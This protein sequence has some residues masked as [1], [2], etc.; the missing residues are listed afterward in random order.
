MSSLVQR[1]KKEGTDNEEFTVS[2]P[3][4][5]SSLNGSF[6]H[7]PYGNESETDDGDE[8]GPK[9]SMLTLLEEVYL[10]GLKDS[11]VRLFMF[12]YKRIQR[13]CI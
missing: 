4:T 7:S 9:G 5:A 6:P 13:I 10:L 8:K 12:V 2:S 11:Q 3:N 1:R